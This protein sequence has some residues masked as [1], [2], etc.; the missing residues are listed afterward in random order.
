MCACVCLSERG[1]DTQV[2]F[3]SFFY[4]FVIVVLPYLWDIL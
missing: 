2:D 1:T 3:L 4:I